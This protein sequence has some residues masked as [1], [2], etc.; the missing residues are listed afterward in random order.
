MPRLIR[1]PGLIDPHVHLREP[2]ATQKEDFETG[3]KAA[4][5]GGYTLVLDMPNNP[6]P[7]ITPEALEKK[8]KLAQGVIPSDS[9]GS[10]AEDSSQIVQN[11]K[12]TSRIYCDVGFHFGASS[13]SIQY[14][15]EVSPKVFGLKVYMNQTTGDLLMEDDQALEAVFSSWPKGKPILVH[16]EGDTLQKAIVLAKK[17][18]SRLHV[19]HVSLR[20]EI[21]LIKKAKVNGLNLSCEV[22]CHHLFLTEEDAKRLGPYGL[23]K[24]P[25]SG[26][27]DQEALWQALVNGTIDII[28]SDHAPHTKEEKSGEKPAYGVPG[29]ET[30]LPLL[31]TAVNDGRLTMERLIELT[32]TNPRKIFGVPDQP[33]TF[34]EVDMDE[35]YMIDDKALQTKCGWTPFVGMKV[36]GKVKKVVLRGKLVY[37][38]E[39]IF[40]PHGRLMV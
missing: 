34:V 25:L 17:F 10:S 16:A 11:D 37:D 26:K 36:T 38:G 7:T 31:L 20:K 21:E 27:E 9:E 35:S 15:N 29:L 30:S 1:L 12:S 13:K 22:S 8:I 4:I 24:P 2:G 18:G 19:C 5:A 3:T 33:E 40:G 39:N 28:A 23:M 6:E 32:S 14:F